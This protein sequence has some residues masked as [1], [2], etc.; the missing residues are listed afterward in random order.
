MKRKQVLSLYLVGDPWTN[1]ISQSPCLASKS[2]G[3]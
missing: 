2:V 1:L 3:T